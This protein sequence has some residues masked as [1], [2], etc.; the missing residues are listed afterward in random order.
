[1]NNIVPRKPQPETFTLFVT[2]YVHYRTGKVMK[3]KDYGY[4]AWPL[5]IRRK[6]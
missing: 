1:M 2:E 6:K 3:A 5:R 4:E